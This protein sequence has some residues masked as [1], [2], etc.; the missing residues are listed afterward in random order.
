MYVIVLLLCCCC[1]IEDD[2]S[3]GDLD[4]QTQPHVVL[5]GHYDTVRLL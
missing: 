1:D 4:V 2:H 3:L 5:F